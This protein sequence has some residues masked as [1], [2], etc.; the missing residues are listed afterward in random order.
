MKIEIDVLFLNDDYVV[1]HKLDKL[2][3]NK[4]IM[5]IKNA[6]MVIEASVGKFSSIKVGDQLSIW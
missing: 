1:V 5:P 2:K 4:I 3:K 6:S